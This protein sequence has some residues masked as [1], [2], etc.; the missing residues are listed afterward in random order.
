MNIQLGQNIPYNAVKCEDQN[1]ITE[2]QQC[3]VPLNSSLQCFI[4]AGQS[5]TDNS[6]AQITQVTN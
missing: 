3:G 2:Q 6:N 4:A 5:F 1:N